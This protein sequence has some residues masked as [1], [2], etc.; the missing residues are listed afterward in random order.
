MAKLMTVTEAAEATGYT[1]QYVS[2]LIREG[3]IP[4]TKE[5]RAYQI[6]PKDLDGVKNDGQKGRPRK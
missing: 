2:R 1:P 3:K 5:G 6:D 4:A